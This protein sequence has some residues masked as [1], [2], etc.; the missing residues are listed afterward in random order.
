M[1]DI[2]LINDA[3]KKHRELCEYYDAMGCK[4]DVLVQERYIGWLSELRDYKEK[5]K[6]IG[7]DEIRLDMCRDISEIYDDFKCS[8]CIGDHFVCINCPLREEPCH[9][10]FA[11]YILNNLDKS[12]DNARSN[13][14]VC[15][16]SVNDEA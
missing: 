9:S 10:I 5:E 16:R 8:R 12:A 15:E 14:R 7:D 13:A 3:I 1:N 6:T 11:R 2:M 4:D